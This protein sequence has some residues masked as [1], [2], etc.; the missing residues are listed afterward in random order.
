MTDSIPKAPRGL[1]KRGRTF[2]RATLTAFEL[3]DAE[4]SILLEVCRT[5][6]DLDRL[7]GAIAAEGAMTVGS[8]G[9]P[10]VNPALTEARGQRAVLH[11]LLAALALPDEDGQAVPTTGT[12]RAQNAAKARWKG[13]VPDRSA[14]VWSA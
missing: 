2:W 10:V 6:D 8:Q 9:Q 14:R 13:H 5:L 11:R 3:S 12:L 1:A 4:L 7:A